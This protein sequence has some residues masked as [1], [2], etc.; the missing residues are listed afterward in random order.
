MT[1]ILLLYSKLNYL[2]KP[3]KND[4]I[5]IDL[6]ILKKEDYNVL[7]YNREISFVAQAVR[8]LGGSFY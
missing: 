1:K 7:S 3:I 8:A 4:I 6:I 5:N 2:H